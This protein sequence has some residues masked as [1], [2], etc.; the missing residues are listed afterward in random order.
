M[1][2]RPRFLKPA[3]VRNVCGTIAIVPYKALFCIAEAVKP[4]CRNECG[5]TTMKKMGQLKQRLCASRSIHHSGFPFRLGEQNA[6]R[7]I[8]FIMEPAA[9]LP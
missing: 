6:L 7:G 1:A 8:D 4:L 5:V 9:S 2:S 3:L